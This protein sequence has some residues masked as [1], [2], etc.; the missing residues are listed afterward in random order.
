[1]LPGW[2]LFEIGVPDELGENMALPLFLVTP[3]ITTK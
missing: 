3:I 2:A 1:M